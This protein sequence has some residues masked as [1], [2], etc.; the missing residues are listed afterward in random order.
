MNLLVTNGLNIRGHIDVS[1]RLVPVDDASGLVFLGVVL[2]LMNQPLLVPSPLKS[3]VSDR[4]RYWF[5]VVIFDCYQI[6]FHRIE[7]PGYI[8]ILIHRIVAF[9]LLTFL[10]SL[11]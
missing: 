4:G 10:Y 2:K 6:L 1:V 7:G 5:Y 11:S 8:R 9:I 3:H